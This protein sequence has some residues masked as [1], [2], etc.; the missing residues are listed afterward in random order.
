MKIVNLDTSKLL[1]FR[2]ASLAATEA[3]VGGKGQTVVK[4]LTQTID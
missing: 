4:D 3:K 1:G 2:L